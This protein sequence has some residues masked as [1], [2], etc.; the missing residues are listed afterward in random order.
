VSSDSGQEG[1][2]IQLLGSQ[3]S[4]KAL[5][6]VLLENATGLRSS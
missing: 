5:R 6:T 4:A 3:D 2:N 1:R